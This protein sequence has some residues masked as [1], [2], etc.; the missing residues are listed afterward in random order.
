[1]VVDFQGITITV[2]IAYIPHFNSLCYSL[3]PSSMVFLFLK[4][5]NEVLLLGSSIFGTSGVV[6]ALKFTGVYPSTSKN[7][8]L[9][10]TT[11]SETEDR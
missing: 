3:F 7:K 8:L 11:P 10:S 6:Y 9:L 2:N 5:L 1:M 4:I